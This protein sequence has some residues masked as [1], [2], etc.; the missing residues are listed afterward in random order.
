MTI[1]CDLFCRVLFFQMPDVYLFLVHLECNI[2][3]QNQA[4][5]VIE[6][7]LLYKVKIF[8]LGYDD[9]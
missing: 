3:N 4:I 7:L 5:N 9:S 2:M 1:E 6:R 8:I